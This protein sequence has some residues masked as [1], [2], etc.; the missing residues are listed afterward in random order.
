[1]KQIIMQSDDRSWRGMCLLRFDSFPTQLEEPQNLLSDLLDML[2]D[3][4]VS[5]ELMVTGD[6]KSDDLQCC[7]ILRW[8]GVYRK[9]TERRMSQET[10]MI[11]KKLEMSGIRPTGAE[12]IEEIE[13][14]LDRIRTAAGR[15]TGEDRTCVSFFPAEH[16]SS[17]PAGPAYLP[18][19]WA[20]G[21]EKIASVPETGTTDRGILSWVKLLKLLSSYPCFC[22]SV[23][24][25]HVSANLP[26]F[27][28]LCPIAS[29]ISG[30]RIPTKVVL[31]M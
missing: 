23:Q 19:C 26:A 6:E 20:A 14:C 24:I 22:F 25:D 7:L 12:T 13:N 16:I 3:L 1:M 21:G 31:S 27:M 28:A 8:R 10:E 17:G 30:A 9:E 5:A 4:A 11:L 2:A 29:S 15:K 18:G